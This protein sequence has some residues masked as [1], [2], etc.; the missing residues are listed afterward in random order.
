MIY[1][2]KMLKYD[3]WEE[4]F[5]KNVLIKQVYSVEELSEVESYLNL[6]KG[7]WTSGLLK[8]EYSSVSFRVIEHHTFGVHAPKVYVKIESRI[9]TVCGYKHT[10]EKMLT[11]DEYLEVMERQ[12]DYANE[13]EEVRYKRR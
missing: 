2:I 7:D 6:K 12:S 11:P 5:S 9:C 4:F 1:L 13:N 8:E 3:G 10:R